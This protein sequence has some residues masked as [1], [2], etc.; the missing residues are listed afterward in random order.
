MSRSFERMVIR[1]L[2]LLVRAQLHHF[3]PHLWDHP[4]RTEHEEFLADS[5]AFL[6][7]ETIPK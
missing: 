4:S 2:V 7:K 6:S 3:H 1:A 5:D